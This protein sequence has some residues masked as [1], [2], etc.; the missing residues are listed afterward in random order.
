MRKLLKGAII[1][2]ALTGATFAAAVPA[3]AAEIVGVHIG[4]VGL[5]FKVGNGHYYDRNHHARSYT[6][7]SDWKTYNH[8]QSWY[9]SHPQWRD[10]R[11]SDWYRG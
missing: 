2:I 10:Q 8:P 6:Y 11:G 5:G 3:S 1:A 4:S 9:R 7:P